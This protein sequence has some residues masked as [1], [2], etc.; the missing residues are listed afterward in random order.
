M[1]EN[2]SEPTPEVMERSAGQVLAATGEQVLEGGALMLGGL[3]AKDA[4]NQ[5]KSAIRPPQEPS[6]PPPDGDED[7]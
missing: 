4:Y 3:M 1:S 2:E 6:S 7:K 5:V